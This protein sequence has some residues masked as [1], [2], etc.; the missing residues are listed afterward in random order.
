MRL[1]KGGGVWAGFKR[2]P[3]LT[4]KVGTKDNSM[5]LQY[6]S[7]DLRFADPSLFKLA[8]YYV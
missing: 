3:C 8:S 4:D 7:I 5:K 6:L 2:P 1:G